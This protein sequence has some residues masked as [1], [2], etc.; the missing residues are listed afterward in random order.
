[1]KEQD[2]WK[3]ARAEFDAIPLPEELNDRILAGIREGRSH[4][5]RRHLGR[6]LSTCAACFVLLMGVL[7]L[8]P[9]AARAAADLPAV[10]GLFQVLT[11]R[12]YRD[13]DG[14]RVVSVTQPELTGSEFTEKVNGEIQE[15][16]QSALA[17]GESVIADYKESYFATGGTQE[18][19]EAHNIRVTVDYA[20]K[21]QTDTRVS[22]VL[23]TNISLFNSYHKQ[24]FYNLDLAEDRELTLRDL[25]G[26]DWVDRCNHSIQSQISAAEDS[27]VYFTPEQGGFTTVD[28]STQ[29][30]INSAGNP[31]VV[32]PRATV[33]IGALGVVE[34]EII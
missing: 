27:A 32:F 31:V 11:L 33:A 3:S 7:N 21:Y 16:V 22:F 14:D 18:E 9:T 17:E 1:M 4:R 5:K 29:F 23:D 30:Y 25:L 6:A 13:V 34:F 19:W 26:D 10:G 12:N 15:R 20:I 8:S 24:Y 28:E 2:P